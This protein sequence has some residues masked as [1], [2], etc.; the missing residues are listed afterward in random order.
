LNWL[1]GPPW[2]PALVAFVIGAFL[3]RFLNRCID[4]FPRHE[5]L[6]EQLKSIARHSAAE[7]LLR[8]AQ[9]LGHRIPV[10]GW[11]VPRHP[12]RRRRRDDLRRA[13]VELLN[14]L[15]FAGLLWVEFPEGFAASP[16]DP[17]AVDGLAI[18]APAGGSLGLQIVRFVAH[19]VLV[20]ALIV[21]SVID[22]DRMIIP[23]GST[24]PAALFALVVSGAT[25]GIWLA[26]V[27]YEDAGLTALLGFGGEAGGGYEV[28]S[29]VAEHPHLHGLLVS[30]A[31]LV[32]GGGVVWAVR[33]IG[34]WAL[35]R[36]AMGFGDVIFLAMIGSFLGW[37]A[38]LVVFFL[39]PLC[40]IAVVLFAAV[41]GTSRE[42]P[43]GPWLSLATVMLLLGWQ[44]IWPY[45]GR[46]FL[47]GRLIPFVAVSILILLAVLL[48][49]MRLI[50]GD[51]RWYEETGAAWSS[52]DQLL[53]QSQENSE[54]SPASWRGR[55]DGEWPGLA[56]ARGT[57]VGNRW[58]SSGGSGG[59]WRVR[60]RA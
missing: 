60:P 28:P 49:G 38:V 27:W 18:L 50:R 21:A 5:S 31:G 46:F 10:L 42:F 25:G 58:R 59:Q 14:G 33:L 4:R 36:E 20:Q 45:A 12:L 43:Y 54:R 52:A 37:Q 23:D 22:L 24:V 39:A 56:S 29:L 15:L 48:R 9:G 32:V 8:A 55:R 19:L 40:A 51:E 6:R 11:L 53:Y 26:P 13:G 57:L 41:T 1:A 34:H 35:G 30:L 2:A 16:P 17:F 3:G 47:M 44:V 7:R